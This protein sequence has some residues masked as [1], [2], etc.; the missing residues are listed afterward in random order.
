MTKKRLYSKKL[1]HLSSKHL[2][3]HVNT[4]VDFSLNICNKLILNVLRNLYTSTQKHAPIEH[5]YD[6]LRNMM[7]GFSLN[8]LQ[9]A[10]HIVGKALK[11]GIQNRLYYKDIYQLAK[12]RIESFAESMGKIVPQL[13]FTETRTIGKHV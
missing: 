6:N 9:V 7:N 3:I 12:S 4:L 2:Q 13:E 8:A 1:N 11:E 10:D 5:K